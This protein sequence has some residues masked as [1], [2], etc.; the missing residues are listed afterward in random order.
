M[1]VVLHL[2]GPE[3]HSLPEHP[4]LG[5]CDLYSKQDLHLVLYSTIELQRC[6]VNFRIKLVCV[7]GPVSYNQMLKRTEQEWEGKEK[8]L[9]E[10]ATTLESR[11]T[12]LSNLLRRKE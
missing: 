6:K 12:Y 5:S 1:K 8:M 9:D 2:Y 4:K 3:K 7:L 11:K 10:K